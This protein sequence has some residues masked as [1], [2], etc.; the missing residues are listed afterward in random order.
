VGDRFQ[1]PKTNE[2]TGSPGF[3]FIKNFAFFYEALPCFDIFY[4]LL[5]FRLSI[6]SWLYKGFSFSLFFSFFSSVFF[7]ALT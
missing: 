1:T 5:V 2:L 4:L 6:E 3:T 7:G